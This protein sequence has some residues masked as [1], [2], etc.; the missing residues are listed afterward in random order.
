MISIKVIE[1]IISNVD[2]VDALIDAVISSEAFVTL[3]HKTSHKSLRYNYNNSQQY[4]VWVKIIDFSFM[5]KIIR[6]LISCSMKIFS[7]FPTINILKLNF[8]LVICIAKNLIWTTLKTISLNISI[9]FVRSDSRFPNSSISAK[10]CHILT[11]HTS[12]EVY[13]SDC[14]L[15]SIKHDPYDWF[16]LPGSHFPDWFKPKTFERVFWTISLKNW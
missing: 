6:I 4:I 3:D 7:Q 8:W 1:K 10:Y 14:V 2:S 15:I 16:C 11:N 13:L 12:M 9:F 5:P